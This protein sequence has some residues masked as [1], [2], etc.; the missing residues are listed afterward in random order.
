MI[1]T[2]GKPAGTCQESQCRC[3]HY[4]VKWRR[5]NGSEWG[6][7]SFASAQSAIA[8]IRSSQ[9]MYRNSHPAYENQWA[10]PQGPLC[11]VSAAATQSVPQ[12]NSNRG[13]SSYIGAVGNARYNGAEIYSAL[14]QLYYR[15]D[16][17]RI[18]GV[19]GAHASSVW[20]L[21]FR[22][23]M[24]NQPQT[25]S[26]VLADHTNPTNQF[27]QT[28]YLRAAANASTG[29]VTATS[30][31]TPCDGF[32]VPDLSVGTRPT[33]HINLRVDHPS[34]LGHRG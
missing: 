31:D 13:N 27:S 17:E 21:S 11:V 7:G 2:D 32:H 18:A 9:N 10:N 14:T 3:D 16:C 19:D 6:S 8:D 1:G 25:V 4:A 20:Y 5:P 12:S 28:V 29:D 15:V 23:A 22:N 34:A 33:E 26:V 24:P 30:L